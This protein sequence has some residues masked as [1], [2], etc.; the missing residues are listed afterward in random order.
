MT[1]TM[2]Q[3]SDFKEVES[4][5]RIATSAHPIVYKYRDWG[6]QYHQ[7]I[8]SHRE[9]W[10]A[11]P[12]TLNDRHDARPPYNFIVE[13]IDWE[14]FRQSVYEAGR[15]W[16]PD[17]PEDELLENV[18]ERVKEA[19]ADTLAYFHKNRGQYVND[20]ARYDQI[21]IFSCCTSGNNEPMWAHYGNNHCGFAVGFDTV[22]LVKALNCSSGPVEYDDTPLDYY[23]L[24][25]NDK[26]RLMQREIFQKAKRWAPEEEFRFATAG[27]GKTRE[28]GSV[29]PAE[30][31]REI[32]FGVATSQA[33][34]A[35]I[36]EE[37]AKIFPGVR[38]FEL[39]VRTDAY[40]FHKTK[41]IR[42]P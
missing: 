30:I 34:K 6:N 37:A 21:G 28:R 39:T 7:R 26:S 19:M 36:M 23:V 38:F 31:V 20:K 41:V 24:G 12:H 35:K 32:L 27:I 16:E 29:F 2:K 22:E 11:H 17:M 10:F 15:A 4:E 5:V 25:K 42:T 14:K 3:Y 13:D 18:E 9:A 1:S 40:G 8:I 33:V